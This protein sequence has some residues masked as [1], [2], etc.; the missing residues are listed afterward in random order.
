MK[1]WSKALVKD[2]NFQ[3]G[4]GFG[5]IGG[6]GGGG[7]GGSCVPQIIDRPKVPLQNFLSK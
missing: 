6:K 4:R 5:I 7:G 2:N 1:E 3:K